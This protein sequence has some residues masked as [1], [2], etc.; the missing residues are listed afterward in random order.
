[1][2]QNHEDAEEVTQEVFIEVFYSRA[3]FRGQSDLFTW[4]YRLAVNKSL[5]FLKAKKRKKRFALFT[6]LFHPNT[7]EPLPEL[8]HFDHPGVLSENKE[9]S[10]ILFNAI[11]QLPENQKTAFVLSKIEGLPQKEIAQIMAISEKATESLI[12]RAKENL[13]NFL[14]NHYPNRGI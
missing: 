5:D 10:R 4:I 13:R 9:D 8:S 12:R 2:V 6:Q 3:R 1:M 11:N 7:G 14:K